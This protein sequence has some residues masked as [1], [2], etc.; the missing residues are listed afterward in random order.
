MDRDAL[1]DA[2]CVNLELLE[3]QYA[4]Y[5]KD[6][7]R[8]ESSLRRWFEE[9]D[10]P[11]SAKTDLDLRVFRLIDA[12]RTYGHLMADVNP[13]EKPPPVPAQLKLETYG[14]GKGD[15]SLTCDTHQFLKEE[16]APLQLV[17]AALKET[18]A[19]KIG[20]EYMG[21][22]ELE[23]WLQGEIEASHP[24]ALLSKEQKLKI[25]VQLNKSEL[26]E[27]F[28]HTKYVG[29]KRF[30]LEGAET[31]IP[32]IEALI[33]AGDTETFVI[34][35]SH[36]GRLNV[37]CNIFNKSYAEV[38]SEFDENYLPSE[39]EG[40]GDVKYHKG[41]SADVTTEGGNKVHLEL[42]PNPSHLDAVDPVVE[43]MARALQTMAHDQ[44]HILPILIHGDAALSGQG[45]IYE[46][47][48]LSKLPGYQTGGSLHFVINNQIGFTTI[49]RDS[50][51]TRYCT[52]IARSFGL[53]V[54]HV[55]AEDPDGCVYATLLA[56][57][58][59]QKFHLDVFID[60]ICY[61]KYGHNEG[62]EPAFTQPKTYQLIRSKKSIRELYRE[63]LIQE[64][65]IEK[66]KAEAS[67]A[68]FKKAL[69]QALS[70]VKLQGPQ[71]NNK[72]TV[73]SE[74]FAT[75]VEKTQ[76]QKLAEQFSQV[77]EGF[78]L[79]PKIATLVKDRLEMA[80][81]EKP[82]D[83]G[84]AETLAY[85]TLLAQG[86]SVRL[87]GQDSCRGTFSHR[88]ALFID[89]E[90]ESA[91]IP[92]QHL[93]TEAL[94]EIYNSPLSE[95]AALGFE[96]GF[97][98]LAENTLVIWEAQFGDFANGG[99]LVIDQFIV[100]SEQKWGQISAVTLFLPHGYEGQGP[101]HS[102][103]RVERF[104]TMAGDENLRIANPTTPAQFFHLLR[105][106]ALN[107]IRKPLAIFTPKGL[108]RNPECVSS[109]DDLSKGH[110][111]EVLDDKT[112]PS[113]PKRLLFCSGRIYYELHAE[114]VKRHADEVALLRI[115]QLY[116]F[117]SDQIKALLKAYEG[118]QECLYVQEEPAN[119]GAWEFVRGQL[120][121]LLSKPLLYVGRERS[122]A[123]AVGSHALHKRQQAAILDEVFK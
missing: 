75:T 112:G 15:L 82:L 36:R 35:M 2:G 49:P 31:L 93:K 14:I 70:E 91:Y 28:L 95:N 105:R 44:T 6:P 78:K 40:S 1:T 123:T 74:V 68:E 62:D 3:E 98:V 85:A 63:K 25:L 102:S 116:P 118:F 50:R 46:T 4:A 37:L 23:G 47:L 81:G 97:S 43:G 117:P 21:N 32:M 5:L 99:Q 122:A 90:N 10:S 119:M 111:N 103:A 42:A 17:V 71:A 38:F 29:Q 58:I 86:K 69:Q 87:T 55:N 41:F 30:S 76:L 9:L 115:E 12:Y 89:Q 52:D 19:G 54:L 8:V 92:L 83:W 34:G 104:L 61:R 108:L 57:K 59:R 107:P 88:H 100:P 11:P 114:R 27:S 33:E 16:K 20:I 53:P 96:F 113:K 60:L 66:S 109:I 73:S 67:E 80:K 110:F 65:I 94:F 51:S 121:P 26:L 18:Y 45:V 48:Q 120:Q 39:K 7:S 64:G 22:S 56:L 77:P 101:E 72:K 106:Q 13:L 79:H 24:Q 84:M